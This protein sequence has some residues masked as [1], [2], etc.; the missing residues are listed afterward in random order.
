MTN[1]KNLFQSKRADVSIFILVVMTVIL[2]T[3]SLFIFYLS[4]SGLKKTITESSVIPMFYAENE[5]FKTNLYYL[6]K[7]SVEELEKENANKQET[8]KFSTA[9]FVQRFKENYDKYIVKNND[10][11]EDYRIK[12]KPQIMN[13]IYDVSF[14][15]NKLLFRLNNFQFEKINPMTGEATM[16]SIGR[17]ERVETIVFEIPLKTS[18]T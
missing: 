10:F 7:T 15:G 8:P 11:S 13:N 2:C 1:S 6:A 12:Y 14:Q 5:I 16:S 4:E 18:K 17:M 9:Q 3:A